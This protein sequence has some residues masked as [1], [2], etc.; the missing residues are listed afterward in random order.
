MNPEKGRRSSVNP[1][2]HEAS[3]KVCSH[4]QKDDIERDFVN[5][6]SPAAIA[7]EYRLKNRASVYRH[8]DAA[9]LFLKRRR[10]VC[11]ALEKIIEKAGEVEVG[12]G[13]VVR[14]VTAYARINAEGDLLE[15]SQRLDRSEMLERMTAEELEQYAKTG[16]LPGW[17]AGLGGPQSGN[18]GGE[19]G[20]D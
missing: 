17:T 10:N 7:R 9:G 18:D 2:R 11:A 15:R 6:E 4:P 16:E 12:A 13:A 3:C 8:A 1:R 5:W 20:N 19:G 14:A